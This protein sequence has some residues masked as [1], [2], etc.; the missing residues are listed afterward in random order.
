[1][2]MLASRSALKFGKR[3]KF[4]F[5]GQE[6]FHRAST[7]WHSF[8]GIGLSDDLPRKRTKVELFDKERHA[9]R[10]KRLKRLQAV[11]LLGQFRQLVRQPDASFRGNQQEAVE[12]VVR[13]HTPILH[14]AGTGVGKT[15]TFMLPSYAASEG[16][17]LVIVPF[18]ALQNDLYD[19]ICAADISCAKWP[20][21]SSY[22]AS[23]ILIT[24]ES[25]RT[26]TFAEFI[27]RM[28]GR[29]QLDRIVF[30]EC[31]VVLDSSYEFRPLIRTIGDSLLSS[32]VQLVFLTATMPPRDEFEFWTTIGVSASRALVVR[33][34]TTRPNIKYRVKFLETSSD[35]DSQV[36]DYVRRKPWRMIVYCQSRSRTVQ[37][38]ELIGC[39]AYHSVAGF[40]AEKDDIVRCWK[41]S[42]GCI[43]ATAALGAGLD[44]PDVRLIVHVDI[45]RS[46]W[47][48][49]QESG[50]AGRDGSWAVSTVL[51]V[52]PRTAPELH[53]P[54]TGLEDIKEYVFGWRMYRCRRTV[55][56]RVMD[57]NLR[58]TGC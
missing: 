15:I 29:Q 11:H 33:G 55:L 36:V 45:P 6:E 2:P 35:V 34:L 1:M 23:I 49:V 14:V 46:L 42:G 57:G 56:E 43:V 8:F 5:L 3:S 41:E 37:L 21:D 32:G 25:F 10:Q 28:L 53:P 17:T 48:F 47:D 9:V 12:A 20:D 50:R 18:V 26:K 51:V 22:D 24:P 16:S 44:I 54:G 13:G 39:E 7:M 4:A 52:R 27:N 19:R 58:C 31:H 40:A 30:D 38:A